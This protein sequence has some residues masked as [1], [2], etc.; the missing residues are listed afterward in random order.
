MQLN[1]H[2]L[3]EFIP[4][5]EIGF[6]NEELNKIEYLLNNI[7]NNI[8]IL[9]KMKKD[10]E[11]FINNIKLKK[12]NMNIYENNPKYN[13]KQYYI[14]CLDIINKISKIEDKNKFN[15]I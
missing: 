2:L 15:R 7:E 14:D 13:F 5:N 8:T 4:F 10:I 3:H 1:N 9:N 12:K 6:N 11:L